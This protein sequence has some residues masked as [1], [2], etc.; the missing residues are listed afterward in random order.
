MEIS[1]LKLI[2]S[3][4]A[5]KDLLEGADIYDHPCSVAIREIDRL[6]SIAEKADQICADFYIYKING[7]HD[8]VSDTLPPDDS[9]DK[10]TLIPLY[11]KPP[12]V[13]QQLL[14]ALKDA[15]SALRYIRET[16]GELYGVGF[17]R[18]ESSSTAA[19]AAA[20]ENNK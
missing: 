14:E 20:Q 13:N 8:G 7:A 4:L 17:D 2:L 15:R 10:G 3:E 9:Y 5:Q 11:K 18:V 12:Q 16:H 19:I 6:Q 1:E